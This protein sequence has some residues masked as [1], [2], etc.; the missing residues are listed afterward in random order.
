MKATTV[1]TVED[2]AAIADIDL[3]KPD[4]WRT[5]LKMITDQIDLFIAETSK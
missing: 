4:F 3:T 5:S 1:N 2:V